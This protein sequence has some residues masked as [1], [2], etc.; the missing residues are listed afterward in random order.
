[1][2]TVQDNIASCFHSWEL[3]VAFCCGGENGR[4]FGISIDITPKD[5]IILGKPFT[6]KGNE[7]VS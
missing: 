6:E 5:D 2:G 3:L 4:F 7:N 1:L